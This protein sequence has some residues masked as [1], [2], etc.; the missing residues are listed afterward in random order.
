MPEM[1]RAAVPGFDSVMGSAAAAV[2]TVVL[3]KASG[4]GLSTACGAVPVPVR[5]AVCGEPMALSATATEALSPPAEAGVNVTVIVQVAPAASEVPQV[6]VSPKLLVFVPVTEMPVIVSA[7]VPGLDRVVDCV[8]AEVPTNVLGNVRVLEVKVACGAVPV[9][10]RA[11]VCGEPVALSATDIEALRLPAEAGVKVTVMVQLA[12]AASEVPQLLLSPKLLE[13]V[14]VT[15]MPVMA[16]A[17]APGFDKVMGSAVAAVPTS[18]PGKA[19]GFGLRT[20]CGVGAGVPVPVRVTVCGEPAALS[21]TESVA[22][23]LVA[24]A[25]VKLM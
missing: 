14:P 24:E 7:A 23:K 11:A 8:V 19:S 4:F 12:P 9:P 2:P 6:L 1:V 15:E 20:A 10:V 18:V 21:A 5:A 3:G 13:F 25:G 16:R 22:E 17:A